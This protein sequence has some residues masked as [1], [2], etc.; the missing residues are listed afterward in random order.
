MSREFEPADRPLEELL[1]EVLDEE[2]RLSEGFVD[3]VMA[4]YDLA[5]ADDIVA[6]LTQDTDMGIGMAPVRSPDVGSRLITFRAPE[7]RFV[8]EIAGDPIEVAGS[9]EP[10]MPG[11]IVFEQAG[12]SSTAQLA[13]LGE[14]EFRLPATTPFRLRYIGASGVSVSTDWIL[15]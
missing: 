14:F 8:F 15:P 5:L 13:E 3:L 10:P 11:I 2:S 4:G 9:I 1:R 7:F 12:H 6:E